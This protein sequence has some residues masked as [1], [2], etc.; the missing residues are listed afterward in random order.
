MRYVFF[1][2]IQFRNHRIR[3]DGNPETYD[4][5]AA[6]LSGNAEDSAEDLLSKL[7][8]ALDSGDMTLDEVQQFLSDYNTKSR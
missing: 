2:D 6:R 8:D 7:E 4:D 1:V 5:L 3:D